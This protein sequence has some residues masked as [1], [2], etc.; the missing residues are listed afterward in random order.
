MNHATITRDP[1]AIA[2]AAKQARSQEL[3]SLAAAAR[4]AISAG[5]ITP[6]PPDNHATLPNG[7]RARGPLTQAHKDAM[8]E[9]NRQRNADLKRAKA[10]TRLATLQIRS[11]A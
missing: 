4:R 10:A 3:A 1:A 9:G 5:I 2:A 6:A 11:P 7:R 8:Q